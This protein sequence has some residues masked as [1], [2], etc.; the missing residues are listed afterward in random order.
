MF[1]GSVVFRSIAMPVSTPLP[2]PNLVT[3]TE[4]VMIFVAVL[5]VLYVVT[6][7]FIGSV[8]KT[9]IKVPASMQ[10][11]D[12]WVIW[13]LLVPAVSYVISWIMLPF[14]I[15]RS[16]LRALKEQGSESQKQAKAIARTGWVL[17][18][19]SFLCIPALYW[20]LLLS[21]QNFHVKDVANHAIVASAV[22]ALLLLI[23]LIT[24][25]VYWSKLVLI[26]VNL[27]A[28]WERH[29]QESSTQA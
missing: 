24:F 2:A 7:F 28:A 5:I 12:L 9:M 3:I 4:A 27:D 22:F 29:F 1:L 8:R 11:V 23:N 14:S 26:R 25:V 16:M 20:I 17:C 6:L 13:L 18:I 10:K 21:H 15:P 19:V